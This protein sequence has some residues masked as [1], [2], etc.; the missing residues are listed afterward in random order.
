MSILLII[1]WGI[2]MISVIVVIHEG[3]HYLAARAFNVRVLEFM[4]GLP[5]PRV[6]FRPK[7]SRTRFGVTAV[8]LGG[9]ARIAGM[10]EW[11]DEDDLPRAAALVYRYGGI[12]EAE[13]LAATEALGFDV[14]AA[15]DAL[16]EWGTVEKAKPKGPTDVLY[17]TPEVSGEKAGT[18]RPLSDPESF[19]A[20]ERS[21]TYLSLP[22]WKRIVICLA[23]PLANLFSAVI[24]MML[25]FTLVGTTEAS[26]TISGVQEGSP[27]EEAGLAEGDTLVSVDGVEVNGWED[28]HA[29]IGEL[30]IGETVEIGYVRDGVEMTATM[31]TVE[32]ES[33]GNAMIGVI[34][35]TQQHLYGIGES[36]SM[37]FYYIGQVVVAI[38]GLINPLTAAET[39]SQ[40]SSIVGVAVVA[41]Q[42]AQTGFA[43]FAYLV[44]GVSIS[45]GLMNL[46][47]LMP[48]DGGRIVVEIIQRIKGCALSFR[49]VNNYSML[50]IVLMMMLFVAV[51][52]QDVLNIS[53]GVYPM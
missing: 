18:R 7:G 36:A 39:I 30:E 13:T 32:S 38:V 41:A 34:A 49:A 52:G 1:F 10:D 15:L 28:F 19:I 42:A 33:T 2:V 31:Q 43:S 14:E 20:S 8:P 40:S 17:R 25:V 26:T 11:I 45:I 6:G 9:Y 37:A 16:S 23:G 29:S 44:A 12:T 4:V 51:M 5:G 53:S 27:A 47:P 48:L 3:G 21:E 22:C 24:V 46:L 35:G 50:G